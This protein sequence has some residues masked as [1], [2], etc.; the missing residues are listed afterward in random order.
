[1]GHT[2]SNLSYALIAMA[3][4][5]ILSLGPPRTSAQEA[6]VKIEPRPESSSTG[7]AD[8]LAPPNIRVNSDLVL[9]PVMVTD[10]DDH[11][12][13]GLEKK[14][15]KVFDDKVEQM[16]THFS[17]EDAP[18]SI[19]VVFDCSGSMGK[20]LQKSR[21]AVAEF[22][23]AANPDDEFSLVLFNE[24]PQLAI[25]FTSDT[26]AIR[27]RM[28]FTKSEGQTALIDAIFLSVHEMQHARHSRKAILIIS[29]GGDNSSRYSYGDLKKLVREADVQIY[30]IGILEPFNM[31]GR[32]PEEMSGPALL[33]DVAHLT[34][35]R[36]FE[37]NDL[38][39]LSDIASKIGAALRNQYVLGFAPGELKR[40]GKYHHLQVKIEQPKGLPHMRATFRNGYYAR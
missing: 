40:D 19:G 22:M 7:S 15:F 24:R 16:I 21:A 33:D 29:D 27:D 10:P 12:I 37:V 17:S 23:R 26:G 11:L 20:K 36:L 34:G 35:G 9:V 28:L 3:L 30:S 2:R 25:G 13:T 39:E 1:M 5:V 38:N 4:P 18:V 14:H 32:S 8:R 6:R 31:R